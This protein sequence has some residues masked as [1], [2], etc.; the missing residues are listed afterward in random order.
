MFIEDVQ[1]WLTEPPKAETVPALPDGFD[2]DGRREVVWKALEEMEP[3]PY[4]YDSL[5]WHSAVKVWT[6]PG[7]VDAW[8]AAFLPPFVRGVGKRLGRD[9]QVAAVDAALVGEV[10]DH[11]VQSGLWSA[12]MAKEIQRLA[13][14]ATARVDGRRGSADRSEIGQWCVEN[15][16]QRPSGALTAA[17]R[18]LCEL[19]GRDGVE[20][21]LALGVELSVGPADPWR[22]GAAGLAALAD[23]PQAYDQDLHPQGRSLYAR[24]AVARMA[25]MGVARRPEN[26]T[27][28]LWDLVVLHE[29]ARDLV[30]RVATEPDS[31][32]RA[33]ARSLL[34][35]ERGRVTVEATG[36]GTVDLG[37][38]NYARSVAH[39]IRNLT[40]PLATALNS[41]WEELG[42]DQP[43]HARRQKLRERIDRSTNRLAEFATEAVRLSSAVAPEDLVLADVMAE[44][45]TA[46]ES[47]RNGRISLHIADVSGLKINGARRDWVSAFINLLRNAAQVRAGRGSV[48]VSTLLDDAGGLHLYV[49]DDGPGVPEDLRERVFDYGHSTRGGSG[50]GLADA[51]RTAVVSGGQL[52]CED[53]P[54]GGARF[55][56]ALPRRSAG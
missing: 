11:G 5:H 27:D 49:D 23:G 40:L 47:E 44:A 41:L 30:V 2:I 39:E 43:D 32:F 14:A 45:A 42:Q 35:V 52:T 28:P 26:E 55:H 17:G 36:R 22:L 19:R 25:A 9:V 48:W 24:A 7:W 4:S 33:L 50:V 12:T 46:T 20:F 1:R 16:V 3:E 8:L 38:M 10:Q 51:R 31:R 53:S 54:Q 21:A 29:E 13:E 56:F 37:D 18:V 34:D 15:A 6:A